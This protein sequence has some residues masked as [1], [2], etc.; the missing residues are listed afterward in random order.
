MRTTNL[1]KAIP[2]IALVLAINVPNA[3]AGGTNRGDNTSAQPGD[4]ATTTRSVTDPEHDRKKGTT[5][6][7]RLETPRSSDD[8]TTGTNK[9]PAD[10]KKRGTGTDSD[11]GSGSTGGRY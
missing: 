7:D 8:A 4:D 6:T 2:F 1:W 9:K 10:S 3:I 5:N 11:T